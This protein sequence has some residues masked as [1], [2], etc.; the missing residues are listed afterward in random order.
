MVMQTDLNIPLE[1]QK[2]DRYVI[3]RTY[4]LPPVSLTLYEALVVFLA[5]RLAIRQMDEG[6]PHVKSALAKIAS[7]LPS[8]LSEQLK[9]AIE[10]LGNKTP[11]K[12]DV[13]IFEQL[14]IAWV[15]RRR[16]KISYQSLHSSETKEWFLEP[17]FIEMTGTGYSTYV[18]GDATSLDRKVI[19]T[20]KLDRIQGIELLD[21]EFE[22]PHGF[23][24]SKL[25][26][27]S[28]GIIWGEETEVKLK[29]AP[30][31]T[32]RVKESVWHI[33]QLIEDTPNGGCILSLR[34]NSALE[35]TPWIRSWGPDVEV[36]EPITLRNEFKK[37]ADQLNKIYNKSV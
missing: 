30:N 10:S 8:P 36:I 4:L 1:K 22:I 19:T 28:W 17:Y 13:H 14:A 25:L 18:V 23:D 5:S 33:S 16:V 34:V 6:N 15:T 2:G 21:T 7:V 9:Q 24:P 35:I 31:V 37:W 32:R 3:S 26:E 29:F 20:F 27:N 12:A 11:S